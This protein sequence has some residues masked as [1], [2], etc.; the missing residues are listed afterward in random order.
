MPENAEDDKPD[1]WYN[2]YSQSVHDAGAKICTAMDGQSGTVTTTGKCGVVKEF[3]SQ[4]SHDG[5]VDS[6]ENSTGLL[7]EPPSP[8]ASCK[9]SA[10]L[11]DYGADGAL[12]QFDR[13]EN[14]EAR[15]ESE[16]NPFGESNL[17]STPTHQSSSQQV[18]PMSDF[19]A[20]QMT[21][22]NKPIFPT[23]DNLDDAVE[24]D[25]RSEASVSG[26]DYSSTERLMSQLDDM[27]KDLDG[28]VG[29]RRIERSFTAESF[30][31]GL[32]TFDSTL[33]KA[34][35]SDL[36]ALVGTDNPDYVSDAMPTLIK[37]LNKDI[38]IPK[39]NMMVSLLNNNLSEPGCWATRV[40][41]AIWRCRTMR[42]NFSSQWQEKKASRKPKKRLSVCIDVDE[43]RVVGG[44]DKLADTQETALD[45]LEYD[46]LDDALTLYESVNFSCE[47]FVD[48][49]DEEQTKKCKPCVA[50]TSHNLGILYMLRG[51]FDEALP[52][53]EQA[54]QLLAEYHGPA[55]VDHIVSAP[56]FCL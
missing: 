15:N 11:D 6:G 25:Y 16:S 39:G 20:S 17:A 41:E 12:A 18:S 3:A 29:S 33:E 36:K 28:L 46:D 37:S 26:S 23:G 52:C 9:S 56:S 54:T 38:G 35:S 21:E 53:F 42:R 2:R 4:G 45:Y 7:Q 43:V 8:M 32:S 55:H 31:T 22:A 50:S 14:D 48:E 49:M 30:S 19:L 10:V 40:D 34:P 51:D 13:I 27:V 47:A 24:E 1:D 44:I 5:N